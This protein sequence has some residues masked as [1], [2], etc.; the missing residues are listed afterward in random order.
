[1]IDFAFGT[2][3]HVMARVASPRCECVFDVLEVDTENAT[4]QLTFP[5]VPVNIP[6]EI[7]SLQGLQSLTIIGNNAFPGNALL[8]LVNI[9]ILNCY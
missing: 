5:G 2:A 6:V 7:G 8:I 4:R 3:Y 9:I 1:M